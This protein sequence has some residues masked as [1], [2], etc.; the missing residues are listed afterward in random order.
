MMDIAWNFVY[1]IDKG[2][3]MG[4]YTKIYRKIM[5]GNSDNNIDFSELQWFVQKTGFTERNIRGDHFTY[6][7]DGIE[8]IINL[9]PDRGKAKGYQIQQ[10]RKIFSKYG[11]G[12]E[13]HE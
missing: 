13:E 7:R 6:E 4:Q 11:L 5:S 1:T 2:I 12:G 9:Q 3:L 10:I 8:E